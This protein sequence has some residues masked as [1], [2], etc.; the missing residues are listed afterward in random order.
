MTFRIERTER[1][2]ADLLD[3]WLAI[4]LDDQAT[5]DRHLRHLEQAIAGL[6]DFARIGPARDDIRPGIRT[7]R[8][9]PY[10]IFYLVDDECRT[11]RIVPVVD[12]RRDFQALFHQ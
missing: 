3:I 9:A 10:L 6:A 8:R 4:A 2:G 11:I 5:A 1:A 7:I 12:A